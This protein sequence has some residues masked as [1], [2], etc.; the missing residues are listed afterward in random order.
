MGS[1]NAYQCYLM[2]LDYECIMY[3]N[4]KIQ[5]ESA[6]RC[7]IYFD[8]NKNI[9]SP[10]GRLLPGGSDVEYAGSPS[11]MLHLTDVW[12]ETDANGNRVLYTSTEKGIEDERGFLFSANPKLPFRKISRKELYNSYKVYHEKRLN[13]EIAKYE[14]AIT[15]E[16]N[17]YNSLSATEKKQQSYRLIAIAKAKKS[18]GFFTPQKEKL[19][20]WFER[21][22]KQNNLADT[23]YAAQIVTWQFE[24]E[25][26]DA[27]TG[28]GF[29][30][31]IRDINFY[32]K[33]NRLISHNIFF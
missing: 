20:L 3:P 10:N 13:I 8:V 11:S 5:P 19:I 25:K 31:W 24:P 4:A 22:M 28:K 30:V 32:D 6:T 12:T 33:T 27:P 17:E 18:L 7:W 16:Q 29:P 23:A 21:V 2:L 14:K 9:E 1:P 15:E 26:L